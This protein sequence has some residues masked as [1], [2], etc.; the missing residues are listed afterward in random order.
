MAGTSLSHYFHTLRHLKMR[1]I[2]GRIRRRLMRPKADASSPPPVRALRRE[3]WQTPAA[4]AP[5]MTGPDTFLFLS[6]EHAL[7]ETGWDNPEIPLL[8][9]YN[10]HY[11]EDLV[12]RGAEKRTPWHAALIR[13]WIVENPPGKGTGWAPYPASLRIVNWIKWLLAGNEPVEGML[14]SLA[15]QTRW[16][17]G[18]LEWH[19]LGNHLFANAKALVFAGL[20]FDEAEA[21][22]WWRTGLRILERE[23]PEQILPDGGQ[24]ERSPMYHALACM[25]MLDMRNLI[26]TLPE[27]R[28]A[29]EDVCTL[30]R[31]I[32]ARLPDMLR[33]LA[34]MT[35]PDGNIAFF[36]DAAFGIAPMTADIVDYGARLGVA[37]PG[38]PR[39][40][41][42]H[43]RESGYI[44]VMQGDFTILIAVAPVGPDYIP[45]HAHA[46]TLSFELSVGRQ[47]LL[48]NT[49]TSTYEPGPQRA[50]ERSTAAHNTVEVAGED[51]SEVWA[52]FRVAR[53]ARPFDL[54]ITQTGDGW[55]ISC[56][57]DGYKRLRPPVVHRRRW[58][59]RPGL[60]R[61]VDTLEPAA[62][63]EAAA[64]WHIHPDIGVE[65]D[66]EGSSGT[67]A[68]PSGGQL[69]W[70]SG[71]SLERRTGSWHPAFGQ[72]VAG[73]H[74]VVPLREGRA[75]FLI[76]RK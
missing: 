75:E 15:V 11:F 58:E 17:L 1:Q 40:G 23:I 48:V 20:F 51:S 62:A 73:E 27:E 43:L 69:R 32:D 46:D 5:R 49:G 63:H 21:E 57:H 35:H 66:A 13:R 56:A 37:V 38:L 53:R 10:L 28:A 24:F 55:R 42:I 64:H 34:V 8:W 29:R 44:R 9:R 25:D 60:L 72:R 68:L 76:E 4:V 36:N 67:F 14:H 71:V 61:I 22:C 59:V 65:M 33:W 31:M 6:R 7:A 30:Y 26:A 52:A 3:R 39:T 19:L 16:L 54:D 70:R 45:G 47:Q 2:V 50:C 74:L 12:A 18:N 41:L